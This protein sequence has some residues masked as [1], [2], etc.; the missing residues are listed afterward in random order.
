MK[1]YRASV[2]AGRIRRD[3]RRAKLLHRLPKPKY[4]AMDT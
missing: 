2:A 3:F 1:S 4:S